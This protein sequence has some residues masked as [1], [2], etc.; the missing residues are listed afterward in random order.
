M[1]TQVP[2]GLSPRLYNEDLAPAEQRTWTFYSLFAMWMSDI[3][4]IGGYTFAAGLFGLGLGAGNVFLS[5]TFGIIVAFMLMN[6]SG[7][8]GQATGL[9]Y[10][11]LAR[12][13]FGTFGANVPALIRGFV[14]IASNGIQTNLASRT[15][16]HTSQ[17]QTP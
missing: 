10:P 2:E 14:A 4:S 9:P 8:M 13:A 15:K 17:L 6:L 16:E 5:L 3:H 7:W 12:I 11:V 1:S